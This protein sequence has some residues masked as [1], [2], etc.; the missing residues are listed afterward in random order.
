MVRQTARGVSDLFNVI[1]M[2][3]PEVETKPRKTLKLNVIVYISLF[4]EE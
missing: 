3:A 4:V 2:S 1:R